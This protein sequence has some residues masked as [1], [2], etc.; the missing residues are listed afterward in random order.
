M[1]SLSTLLSAASTTAHRN[2]EEAQDRY[3]SA[4]PH[5]VSAMCLWQLN[6]RKSF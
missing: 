6:E 4:R 2:R 1:R 5:R 3:Y